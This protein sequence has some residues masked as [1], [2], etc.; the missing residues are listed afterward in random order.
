[1]SGAAL[2]Q[3]QLDGTDLHAAQAGLDHVGQAGSQ[4]AQLGMAEA[5]GAGGLGL[6]DEGAVG[7]VDALGDGNQ[8]VLL[9]IVYPL[10]VGQE[11]VHVEVHLGQVH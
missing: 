9:L 6:A 5:V 7:I 8:A 10:H 1:M 2:Q 4:A 11:L 3:A